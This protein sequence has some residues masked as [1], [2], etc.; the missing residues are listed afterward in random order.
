MRAKRFISRGWASQHNGVGQS[1][2]PTEPQALQPQTRESEEV[3]KE[4]GQVKTMEQVARVDRP[5]HTMVCP[6]PLLVE[7]ESTKD[8]EAITRVIL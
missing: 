8:R 4:I 3:Y 2:R 6:F 1:G 7:G 5:N